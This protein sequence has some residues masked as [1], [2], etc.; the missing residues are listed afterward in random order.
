[1]GAFPLEQRRRQSTAKCALLNAAAHQPAA[2]N[3]MAQADIDDPVHLAQEM[4]AVFHTCEEADRI[5]SLRQ[6]IGGIGA[7][8]ETEQQSAKD[9]L[10]SACFTLAI[11]NFF[12]TASQR[13]AATGLAQDISGAQDRL[14]NDTSLE[15]NQQELERLERERLE[16]QAQ[17]AS[18]ER[19][20][21]CAFL[22]AASRRAYSR[23]LP[24][25]VRPPRSCRSCAPGTRR[26]LSS[27]PARRPSTSVSC[28]VQSTACCVA[29]CGPPPRPFGCAPR[30]VQ[31]HPEPVHKH[32]QRQ[33]GLLV[34]QAG[35]KHC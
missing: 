22:R 3:T 18:Y 32:H 11:V 33:V 21:G 12:F 6:R 13:F 27:C 4:Q 24:G 25:P 9:V 16:L 15:R 31:A 1:M 7:H 29:A 8:C 5:R 28:R 19:D 17:I 35:W 10:R 23:T 26:C 30:A 34:A 14:R 20:H 2:C